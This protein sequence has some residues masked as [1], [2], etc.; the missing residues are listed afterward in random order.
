M[1]GWLDDTQVVTNTDITIASGLSYS[2]FDFGNILG[3]SVSMLPII[4][5]L[6][7]NDS[8]GATETGFPSGTSKK[9]F[10]LPTADSVVDARWS[11]NQNTTANVYAAVDNVPPVGVAAATSPA[12][13]YSKHAGTGAITDDHEVTLQTYTVGGVESGATIV[14]IQPKAVTGE[15]LSTG[16]KLLQLQVISNPAGTNSAS[17]DVQPT[18]GAQGVFPTGWINRDGAI[19]LAPSVTLGTSPVLRIRRPET[20]SRVASVAQAGL[21]VEWE[22]AVE[23]DA[24]A[25][26]SAATATAAAPAASAFEALSASAA[27]APAGSTGSSPAASATGGAQA[28]GAASAATASAPAVSVTGGALASGAVAAATVTAPAVSAFEALVVSLAPAA[29]WRRSRR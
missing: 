17:L 22:P 12:N 4:D 10:L 29:A 9:A 20:A 2:F 7:L 14:F 13:A 28:T 11:T 26:L 6:V 3:A 18:T 25:D 23:T 24:T 8:T 21:Y 19:D 16:T 5:S 1:N 27:F 15:E